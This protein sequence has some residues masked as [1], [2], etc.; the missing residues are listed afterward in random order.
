MDTTIPLNSGSSSLQNSPRILNHHNLL[1]MMNQTKTAM[2]Q[3]I[4]ALRLCSAATLLLAGTLNA[5]TDGL[6]DVVL[7]DFENVETVTE[8]KPLSGTFAG[9]QTSA[10]VSMGQV[11]VVRGS[12]ELSS[13]ADTTA[14]PGAISIKIPDVVPLSP[15][16][17]SFSLAQPKDQSNSSFLFEI[18]MRDSTNG[19]EYA[20]Q[21]SPNAEYFGG[22]GVSSFNA[23]G[24]L[25]SGTPYASLN[26]HGAAQEI[27]VTFDPDEGLR[28]LKD[29]EE[30]AAFRNFKRLEKIDRIELLNSPAGGGLIHWVIDYVKVSGRLSENKQ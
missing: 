16:E 18:R 15:L 14:T 28:V 25:V 6:T 2:N 26:A 13:G 21:L 20:I 3:T 27:Q 5:A 30:V 1:P 29:G 7:L 9:N 22:S 24:Q 17:L 4:T 8:G 19:E 11:S 23:A 12:A 10:V